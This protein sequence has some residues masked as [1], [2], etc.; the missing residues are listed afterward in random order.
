MSTFSPASNFGFDGR[1]SPDRYYES[2]KKRTQNESLRA[3][4]LQDHLI[5]KKIVHLK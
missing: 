1:P 4:Y 3:S 2:E 5:M